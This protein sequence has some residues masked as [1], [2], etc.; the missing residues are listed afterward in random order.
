MLQIVG[1]VLNWKIGE[2][3]SCADGA[4]SLTCTRESVQL[5]FEFQREPA[6]S[7]IHIF[8]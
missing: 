6:I 2:W 3:C 8:L 4:P 7:D 5:N 1:K